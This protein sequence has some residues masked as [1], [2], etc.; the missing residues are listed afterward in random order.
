MANLPESS[1][2]EANIYQLETTDP[3]LGGVNGVSNTQPKQLA[4]RTRWLKDQVDALNALK[5]KGVS[6]FNP[7]SSYT[8]GDQVIY[9]NNIWAANTSISPGAFNPSQWTA[10]F[11]TLTS[12]DDGVRV[13]TTS[14]VFNATDGMASI[15]V[16]GSADVTVSAAQAGSAILRLTGALTGNINLILPAKTGQWVIAN[17]ATGSFNITVKT[18]SG[19]GVVLPKDLAV[20][21]YCDGT[22]C[23]LAS[24]SGK[25]SFT[26]HTF[27]PAAGTTTLTVIGGYTPGNIFVVKNGVILDTDYY[28]ATTSPTITLVTPST[29]GDEYNVFSF[30][31]FEVANAVKKSGDVMG[32]ALVLAGGD[33]GVTPSLF[34][35]DTSLA[36]TAFVKANGSAFSTAFSLSVSTTLTTA[37][38][39]SLVNFIGSTAG[40]TLT[41]PAASGYLIGSRLTIH[42][43]ATQNVTIARAGSDI[44]VTRSSNLSTLTLLPGEYV[45]LVAVGATSW[46]LLGSSSLKYSKAFEISSATPGYQ[47]LPS[48]LIIQWGTLGAVNGGASATVTFPVTFPSGQFFGSATI[49]APV[50]NATPAGVG[51][52]YVSTSQMIIR[53]LGT[54]TYTYLWLA[55]GY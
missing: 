16:T 13:A 3:V 40:Q 10:Q 50:D 30:E 20:I 21:V 26:R 42:N 38:A 47:I 7:A 17:T 49:G 44:M 43:L 52:N 51:V 45:E 55:L 1:T 11:A 25:N 5:G 27:N 35:N 2:F 46:Y 18:A 23:F 37:H 54:N 31:S 19:T 4:N 8:G 24:S 6:I 34:D 41:L 33:T 14:F 53:N 32:G 9:Q 15:N 22:N 29:A 48:G 28:N 39:N 36:T 12:G